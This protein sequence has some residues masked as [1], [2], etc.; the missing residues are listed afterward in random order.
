M[1][2]ISKPNNMPPKQ[3][4][5]AI[6]AGAKVIVLDAVDVKSAASIVNRAKQSKIRDRLTLDAISAPQATGSALALPA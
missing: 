5:Q 1:V 3:A 2:P 4:E 6:T